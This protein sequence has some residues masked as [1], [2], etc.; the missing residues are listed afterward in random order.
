V[1]KNFANWFTGKLDLSPMD[2]MTRLE[3]ALRAAVMALE[4]I[5]TLH[6]YSC[7]KSGRNPKNSTT[8]RIAQQATK[9][10]WELTHD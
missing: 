2:K 8:L 3:T 4:D 1:T 5:K 10:V 6:T 9:R 7:W